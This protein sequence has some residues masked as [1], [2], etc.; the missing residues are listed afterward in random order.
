VGDVTLRVASTESPP[1]GTTLFVIARAV[2]SPGPPVAVLRVGTGNW[3]LHFQ[4]DDSL[5]MLPGRT[6]S[7]AGSVNVQ[8]RISRSGAALPAAGDL[9][10]S[11]TRVDPRDARPLHLVIDQVVR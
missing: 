2:D 1:A 8:A 11:A 9:E 7:S 5:A 4:L 3:P 6:L 10:S